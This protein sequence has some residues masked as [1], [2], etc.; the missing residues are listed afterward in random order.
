MSTSV[1]LVGC[2]DKN[3]EELVHAVSAGFAS[4]AESDLAALLQKSGPLPGDAIV[5]DLRGRDH[6]PPFLATI[7]R[8][9]PQLGVVIVASRLD[10]SLMLDAMHAGVNEW[11][12]EP[13]TESE[14]GAA[15]ARV[16]ALRGGG[17]AGEVFAVLGAKGGVG[18]TT[19]AVNIAAE[20]AKV[21]KADT[22]LIDLHAAFGDA[23]VLLD[24]EPRFSIV[25]A[26][27]NT[28]RLDET[29]FRS[30][31]VHSSCGV[32][33]LA[34]TERVAL[35][36]FDAAKI[37]AVIDFAARQY[38][39]TV[40]DVPRSEPAALNALEAATSI[41]VVTNQELASVRGA[42]RLA[43]LM[44]NR[45]G[46]ERVSVVVNRYDTRAEISQDDLER[47]IGGTIRSFIPSSYRAAL[48]AMNAGQPLVSENHN[49]LSGPMKA[50][51]HSLARVDE[52]ARGHHTGGVLGLFGGHDG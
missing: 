22:L 11:V 24:A 33:L 19:I 6:L 29:F 44:R 43:T 52:G 30:L 49:S 16:A 31:V 39:Y 4:M 18:S 7:K 46:K 14:L 8:Q 23:A 5:I 12:V 40:L 26:I 42:A 3:L 20:L 21:A 38:P 28:H 17:P 41:V 2:T 47:V 1:L 27:E 51:A 25:D 9:H 10:P 48:R 32:D 36:S 50:L 37:R 35:A 15:L 34:S 45:Y 13:L